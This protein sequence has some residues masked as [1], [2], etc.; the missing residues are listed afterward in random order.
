VLDDHRDLGRAGG[1]PAGQPFEAVNDLEGA[2]LLRHDPQRQIL[3]WFRGLRPWLARTKEGE[4]G[5]Q[6]LD[7]Q[8]DDEAVGGRQRRRL[9]CNEGGRHHSGR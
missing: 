3:E 6:P 4:A 1:D 2:V 7:G 5:A 9:R 8:V